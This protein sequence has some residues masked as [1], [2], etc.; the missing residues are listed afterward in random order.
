MPDPASLPSNPPPGSVLRPVERWRDGRRQRVD[1]PVAEEVPVAFVYN[2]EPFAVMMATP[3]DL[4]DFATGFALSEGIVEHKDDVVVEGIET[5]IEGIEIRL[6]IPRA[7]QDALAQ[8]RR[9]MGGRS[10]CGICGSTLLEAALRFPPPVRSGVRVDVTALRRALAG[11]Q[12]A[13]AITAATGALHAA[14][15]ASPDGA[16][17][18][19]REDVGRHNAL[20]KLIGAMHSGGHDPAA[21]FLV[22]T[23]RASYEMAMKAASV[24]IGFL[25]A[26]SAPTALAISLS[27]RAG[28]TL[29]GFARDDGQAVYAHGHRL[30]AAPGT[31]APVAQGDDA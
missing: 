18:L 7:R 12:R 16:L 1:D 11:L 29:V 5:L 17:L 25:A 28:L 15:W 31:P 4:A 21:G 3:A 2:G 9:S 26:I 8:R 22:V 10:G 23:S 14:G 13:Q 20:D 6:R 24:G 27:E 30:L 19:A